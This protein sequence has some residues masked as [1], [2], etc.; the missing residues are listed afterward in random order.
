MFV[1]LFHCVIKNQ[2]IAFDHNLCNKSL[3]NAVTTNK[4][5][6]KKAENMFMYTLYILYIYLQNNS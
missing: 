3:R 2:N 6:I 5:E 4:Y 1:M